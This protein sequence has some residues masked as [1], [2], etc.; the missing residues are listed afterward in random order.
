MCRIG[1]TAGAPG[2]SV[3]GLSTKIDW[4]IEEPGWEAV[5]KDVADWLARTLPAPR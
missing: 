1:R 3:Q 5:A 2:V 4:F